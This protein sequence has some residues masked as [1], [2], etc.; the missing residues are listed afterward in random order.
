MIFNQIFL[1]NPSF[2]FLWSFLSNLFYYYREDKLDRTFDTII[3]EALEEM[4]QEEQAIN[5]AVVED[6]AYWV[7][8]NAFYQA[9]VINGVID[10]STSQPINA[11]DMSRGDIT[12]M[13]F[14]LDHLE[15][16]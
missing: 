2:A 16:G 1:I 3:R 10:K 5:V 6:K 14:I 8:E 13:L 15:E 9:D 7:I 12:K 4:D 11:F